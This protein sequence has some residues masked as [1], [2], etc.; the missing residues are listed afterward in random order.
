MLHSSQLVQS[1]LYWECMCVQG[2]AGDDCVI[3]SAQVTRSRLLNEDRPAP[4]V[5]V[6]GFQRSASG[7]KD[8]RQAPRS[9]GGES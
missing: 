2:V 7:A 4:P 9:P 8:P 1:S 3:E 6:G 5:A